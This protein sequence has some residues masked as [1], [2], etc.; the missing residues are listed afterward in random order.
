MDLISL[1]VDSDTLLHHS[2]SLSLA[3]SLSR[4]LFLKRH[5]NKSTMLYAS[6]NLGYKS[7]KDT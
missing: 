1:K 5:L 6:F 2:W 7:K 4:L 3:D